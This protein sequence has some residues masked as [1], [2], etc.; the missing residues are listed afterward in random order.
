MTKFPDFF[1]ALS[2]DF[3]GDVKERK[4]LDK[5]TGKT[6]I[7]P[8]VTARTVMNR[9]D[10]VC[11]PEGWFA[12]YTETRRGVLCK[13]SIR[14]P[15]DTWITKADAGGFAGMARPGYD[16]KSGFSDALKRAAAQFGLGRSLYGD[17][18]V[19]FEEHRPQRDDENRSQERLYDWCEKEGHLQR[20]LAVAKSI[21]GCDDIRFLQD[22]HA[23]AIF[24]LLKDAKPVANLPQPA[25]KPRPE[26]ERP[27]QPPAAT[28]PQATP[29][30]PVNENGNRID[31]SWPNG[32]R[33][34]YKWCIGIRDAF[35]KS[36]VPLLEEEFIKGYKFP[37]KFVDWSDEQVQQ[38]ALFVASHVVTWAGY[39]GQ[40]DKRF[41]TATSA[42]STDIKAE[43]LGIVIAC[44][45]KSG[46]DVN[47]TNIALTLRGISEYNAVME[48]N[49]GE[50]I[51]DLKPIKNA[52]VLQA[53]LTAA[54]AELA[55]DY[56]F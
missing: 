32:G 45:E 31:L 6:L 38:G 11:G 26:P 5:K 42:G 54:K 16:E 30:G 25:A 20:A 53:M 21:Y 4:Q 44:V 8:Y 7:F 9:L 52:A 40:F 29:Q 14:L 33:S 1:K 41:A 37:P 17:G 48:L 27:K 51:E 49:G 13:L 24:K 22:E 15:D 23:T 28:R 46:L 36:P 35:K 56:D 34:L 50:V 2:A 55:Q 43:I 19:Q 39:D 10:D 12:D 18:M 47:D 3:G